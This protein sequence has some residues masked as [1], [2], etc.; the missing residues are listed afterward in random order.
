MS[1][2]V[3]LKFYIHIPY[4]NRGN[5]YFMHMSKKTP[6]KCE[7]RFSAASLIQTKDNEMTAKNYSRERGK[8]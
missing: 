5:I 7:G 4:K 8:F 3:K 1:K 6:N 2:N